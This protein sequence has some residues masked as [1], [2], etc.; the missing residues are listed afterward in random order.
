MV[1]DTDWQLKKKMERAVLGLNASGVSNL[2]EI[3]LLVL[4]EMLLSLN[5]Q[6]MDWF[7]IGFHTRFLW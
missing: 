7:E 2:I 4:C 6:R 1:M 5:I 3:G